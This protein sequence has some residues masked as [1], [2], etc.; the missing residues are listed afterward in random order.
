MSTTNDITGDHIYSVPTEAYRNNFED[1]FKPMII[2]EEERAVIYP[3]VGK[4]MLELGDKYNGKGT[5]KDHFEKEGMEHTSI[6]W[7]GEHGALPLDL[8][9]PIDLEP[10]DMITNMGTTE[11]VSD[12]QAVWTNI[13]NLLKVGG[14]LC[15]VTPLEG[16]WLSHGE[17]YPRKSF[18]EKFKGYEIEFM[19]EYKPKH[20]LRV[21]MKKVKDIEFIL[22]KD[23]I[24][25][26]KVT[27]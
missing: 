1:I 2:P 27:L 4:R 16:W 3:L 17:H 19:D 6:D 8:R 9:E 23:G 18:F 20:L 25:Y 24:F 26:N 10:F 15:S 22:P 13:H 7:N 12:Q 5:Y 21:R 11:H 14:I